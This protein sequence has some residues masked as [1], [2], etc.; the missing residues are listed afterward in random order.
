L[1]PY[2]IPAG[3][4][5]QVVFVH[6]YLQLVFDSGRISIHN[7]ASLEGGGQ[8]RCTGEAGFADGLVQLIG[9]R[10]LHAELEPTLTLEFERGTRL[11]VLYGTEDVN[12]PES[13]EI[14]QDGG[15][16][17]VAQNAA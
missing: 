5:T 12:G 14:S 6:D 17:T 2:L 8:Q 4:L 15:G 1:R 11:V 3:P 13:F 16:I 7:R 9:Q 10:V